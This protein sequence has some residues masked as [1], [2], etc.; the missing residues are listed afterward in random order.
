MDTKCKFCD[1]L[2]NSIQHDEDDQW[3]CQVCHIIYD[4]CAQHECF[5]VEENEKDDEK[6]E[7]KN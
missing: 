6:E 2:L 3:H 5:I 1:K 4:G 7:G